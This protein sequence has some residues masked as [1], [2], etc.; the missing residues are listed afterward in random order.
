MYSRGFSLKNWAE[1]C[2][3]AA[4]SDHCVPNVLH[5]FMAASMKVTSFDLIEARQGAVIG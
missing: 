5:A 3:K 2:V 1:N 4:L